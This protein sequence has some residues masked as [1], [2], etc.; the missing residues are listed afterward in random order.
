MW[1]VYHNKIPTKDNLLK[2]GWSGTTQCTLCAHNE[3]VS[4]LFPT[5]SLTKRVWF[6]ME[7]INIILRYGILLMMWS[8]L[9]SLSGNLRNNFLVVLYVVCWVHWHYKNEI[10]FR[11]SPIPYVKSILCLIIYYLNF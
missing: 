2:N 11:V 1:L 5:Y 3:I 4:H 6:W 10:T 9:Q 7:N 8:L